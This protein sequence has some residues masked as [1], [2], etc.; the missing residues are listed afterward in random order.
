MQLGLS[1]THTKDRVIRVQTV[2]FRIPESLKMLLAIGYVSLNLS[3]SWKKKKIYTM[4]F[5]ASA[6]ILHKNLFGSSSPLTSGI[7]MA[8]SL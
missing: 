6:Y 3:S 2:F 1:L 4:L 5:E 8:K 7:K